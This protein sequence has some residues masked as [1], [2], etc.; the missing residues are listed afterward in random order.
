MCLT[1]RSANS[2][3]PYNSKKVRWKIVL[4][5]KNGYFYRP[6]FAIAEKYELNKWMVANHNNT[7]GSKSDLHDIGFHVFV[8]REDAREFKDK[9]LFTT[10][11]SYPI[12]RVEVDEFIA[13][14]RFNVTFSVSP[15]VRSETWKKM[16]IV[17]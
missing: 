9:Y 17:K 3:K 12:M 8:T 1:L 4:K 16:R 13:S 15:G 2:D 6:A 5:Y 7:F 11:S 10:Q 14:G